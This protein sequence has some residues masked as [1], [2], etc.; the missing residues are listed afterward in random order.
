M[1]HESFGQKQ[2]NCF[3]NHQSIRKRSN[4]IVAYAGNAFQ[5]CQLQD[6]SVAKMFLQSM[7]TDMVSSVGTSLNE[8][9]KLSSTYY[10]DKKPVSCS[11]WFWWEDH[12]EGAQEAA[13]EAINWELK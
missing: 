9:I 1:W 6:Y 5:Y 13:E 10:D 4:R 11:L 7:N 12:S 3:A 8:A 2:T